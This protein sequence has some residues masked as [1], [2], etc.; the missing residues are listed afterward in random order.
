MNSLLLLDVDGVIIKDKLLLEHV[1]YNAVQYVRTKL[2]DAKDPARVNQ[3]LYNR[4]GHTARGLHNAFGIDT[5]DFNTFV[6]D[7]SLLTHL[8]HVLMSD[9]FKSDAEIIRKLSHQWD[10]RL[11][12]NAPLDWTLPIAER[13]GVSVSHD[14]LFV[15]PD[16]RVYSKFPRDV[17]KYY[18]DDSINNL[19][20]AGYMYNWVP[21]H[22]DEN[23]NKGPGF[24]V[25]F[26]TVSSV[27]ELGLFMNSNA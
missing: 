25:Q 22:F 20:T 19:W 27:W 7:E 14:H 11:F 23:T 24:D 1:K 3:L 16:P 21:I 12:S 10:T 18:V 15:K 8:G 4:Y 6:Y 13:L 2:P 26:P 9:E 17:K 5:K